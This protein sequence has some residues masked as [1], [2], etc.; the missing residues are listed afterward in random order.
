MTRNP[1]LLRY[2][3]FDALRL[4]RMT[5][6]SIAG[7][8]NEKLPPQYRYR[9]AQGSNEKHRPGAH[10][11]RVLRAFSLPAMNQAARHTQTTANVISSALEAAG[12]SPS[13]AFELSVVI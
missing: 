6:F 3:F 11:Q 13:G 5:G 2:G 8:L 10:C 1:F 9:A 7:A 12:S 4:L